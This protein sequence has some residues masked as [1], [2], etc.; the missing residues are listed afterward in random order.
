[1]Y[2]SEYNHRKLTR[3]DLY[4]KGHL[5]ISL[6]TD[7]SVQDGSNSKESGGDIF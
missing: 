5:N 6:Y 1:M 2:S 7:D 4:K 3:Y